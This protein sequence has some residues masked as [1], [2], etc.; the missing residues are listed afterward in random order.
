MWGINFILNQ[1][2]NSL[3][4]QYSGSKSCAAL[5]TIKVS[6]YVQICII[7]I[8]NELLL[9]IFFHHQRI[10]YC[11]N[12]SK[13]KRDHARV[14]KTKLDL[15]KNLVCQLSH[16]SWQLSPG[17]NI[18]L[19][20]L[21][22]KLKLIIACKENTYLWIMLLDIS[23]EVVILDQGEAEQFHPPK[24]PSSHLLRLD[25]LWSR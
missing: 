15:A 6:Y 4:V 17:S 25:L 21:I 16:H 24:V 13:S 2:I 12:K 14:L 18:S 9:N 11:G 8:K 3:T 1:Y 10:R 19:K 20:Y 22:Y 7:M 23:F 5:W